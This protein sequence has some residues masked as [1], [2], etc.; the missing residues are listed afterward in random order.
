VGTLHAVRLAMIPILLLIAAQNET[1]GWFAWNPANDH[2]PSVIGMADWLTE[3]AGSRGG[4]RMKGD[5]FTL[6][7]GSTIKFWGVNHGNNNCAPPHEVA[8]VRAQRLQKY[9]VNCV[10]LHKFT[11]GDGGGIGDPIDSTKLRPDGW[12][13]LDFYTSELKK[14]GIYHGWSHIFGHKLMP[15]DRK[16]V[17]AFDEVVNASSGFLKGSSYGLVNF[18]PDLQELVIEMTVNM[19]RHRNPYTGRTYAEEPSL[20]FI[21]MQNED[22]IFFPT[23]HEAVMKSPTY[24]ALLSRMFSDWLTKKYRSQEKLVAAWG[25]RGLNA[26]PE[27]QKDESLAVRNVFPIAHFWWYSNEGFKDQSEKKGVRQRL[28]DS[29]EFLHETQNS[30]YKRFANAIRKAGYRGPLVG[31]CWQAGDGIPHYYNLRSDAEVGIVDRHNYF[32]G[33]GSPMKPGPFDNRPQLSQPGGFILSTGLQQVKGR[34]FALSEWISLPPNEWAAETPFLVAAYGLGLQGWDASYHFANDQDRFSDSLTIRDGWGVWNLDTPT[35]LGLYPAL[36]RM[37]LR[38]DVREG[39]PLAA[40]QVSLEDLRRGTLAF[41]E[42][43]EQLGDFKGFTGDVPPAALAS[44]KVEIEFT[45]ASRPFRPISF[46]LGPIQ[47][48]TGELSWTADGRTGLAVVGTPAT[49]GYAGFTKGAPV[50]VKGAEFHSATDF[51]VVLLTSL[52][53][54][55]PLESATSALL[56]MVGRA[57]NTGMRMKSASELETVGTGPILLEPIRTRIRFPFRVRQVNVL[58][59][60]GRRTGRTL[61]P[62]ADDTWAF[63]T[64]RDRT[65]YYEV[66]RSAG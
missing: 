17:L 20:A 8:R 28:L 52:D 51:G 45:R 15:G 47:S 59:Q 19:L 62:G 9:G 33:M 58:D 25:P 46:P 27:F 30:F 41:R 29:A 55:K 36:S 65:I 14:R 37:V 60:D 53:R 64:G 21:E 57:R 1:E 11:Y 42:V 34:P 7:D 50:R 24:K 18:A 38:G 63:D 12:D 3:P 35:N 61:S 56:T 22:D 39:R 48:N 6:G 5:R 66:V 49:I 13:R 2:G 43:T 10:R 40:R 23:T 26:Y 4:V 54:R 44:G 31:S 16:R 32:G